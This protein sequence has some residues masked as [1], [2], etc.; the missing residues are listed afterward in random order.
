MDDGEPA[1]DAHGPFHVLPAPARKTGIESLGLEHVAADQKVGGEDVF[2]G[3]QGAPLVG[4]A[5][6]LGGHAA[7][8]GEAGL[9][10]G[11]QQREA[12]EGHGGRLFGRQPRPGLQKAV[13]VGPHVAVEEQ[14]APATRG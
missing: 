3:L 4:Q 2:L 11:L 10:R 1:R 7:M 14:K 13:V 6:R 12:A 8:N 5:V 9:L